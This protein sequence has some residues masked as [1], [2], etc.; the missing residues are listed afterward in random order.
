MTT[1]YSEE[2]LENNYDSWQQEYEA[3]KALKEERKFDSFSPLYKNFERLKP[4][5]QKVLELLIQ[6]L[7]VRDI[8]TECKINEATIYRWLQQ[9]NFSLCLNN[10]Q[11]RLMIEA[12]YRIKR[13]IFKGLYK[14][15]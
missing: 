15:E 3:T 9:D 13:V 5:Q 1:N 14:L 7:T 12:D 8:A 10:W 11:K 4:N 2:D 6:G